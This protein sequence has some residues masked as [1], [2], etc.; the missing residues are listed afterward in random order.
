[1]A[2]YFS[3]TSRKQDVTGDPKLS[4]QMRVVSGPAMILFA[5][6]TCFIAWDILMSLAPKWYSTIYGVVYWGSA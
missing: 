3:S 4:T 5:F 2:W 1:M 6:T